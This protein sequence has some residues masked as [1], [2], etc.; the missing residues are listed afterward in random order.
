MCQGQDMARNRAPLP[1]SPIGHQVRTQV[2]QDDLILCK[3][4]MCRKDQHCNIGI[5]KTNT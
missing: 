5:L 2:K 4:V 1:C 3:N